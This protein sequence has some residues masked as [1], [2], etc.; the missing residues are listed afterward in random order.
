MQLRMLSS[1]SM[2]EAGCLV[3]GYL[4]G[5]VALRVEDT[6]SSLRLEVEREHVGSVLLSP[7]GS[8]PGVDCQEVLPGRHHMCHRTVIARAAQARIGA[9]EEMNIR[10][11]TRS[12]IDMR[13]DHTAPRDSHR[14]H[15]LGPAL[16]LRRSAGV[17]VEAIAAGPARVSM[18]HERK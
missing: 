15:D 7:V 4:L 17:G 14:V 1:E 2:R 8:Y 11:Y 18:V 16:I 5:N 9:V 3:L 6:G 10:V 12:G 13:H